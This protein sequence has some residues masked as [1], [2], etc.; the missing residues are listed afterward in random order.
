[1]SLHEGS[2]LLAIGTDT[3]GSVRMPATMT[4]NAG[5]RPTPGR[6]S[7][8]GIVPLVKSL[9]TAGPLAR[10]VDDL[11]IGF[12]AID[13]RV[14]EDAVVFRDRLFQAELG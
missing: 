11:V 8:D 10:S 2:A 12:G 6:W 9:D 4:G 14:D 5:F 1:M 13:P 7:T 3:A